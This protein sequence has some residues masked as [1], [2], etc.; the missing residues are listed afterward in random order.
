MDGQQFDQLVRGLF[1]SRRS[2]LG[3]GAAA[4]VAPWLADAKHCKRTCKRACEN[5]RRKKHHRNAKKRPAPTATTTSTTTPAPTPEVCTCPSPCSGGRVCAGRTC[6][7]PV[8]APHW[9]AG[10]ETCVP[11]CP[12]GANFVP[13]SCECRCA[14]R[15]SC[16][17]CMGG[18][19]PFCDTTINDP[20][21][22][23][24]LCHLNN[25]GGAPFYADGTM[26]GRCGDGG[27]CLVTCA[28]VSGGRDACQ[29]TQ[30]SCLGDLLA[31]QPLGGG[32]TRCGRRPATPTCGCTSHQECADTHGVGAF[33]ASI[34]GPL[35]TCDDATSFCATQA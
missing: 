11:A 14:E 19:A 26:T 34:T 12:T 23:A 6:E 16:C 22:C 10:A 30:R 25:P 21:S 9:C 3:L 27:Q 8:A 1:P 24:S 5:G 32:P 13:D 15:Q 31:F 35:C 2:L 33:C 28:P 4:G 18:S 20:T 29:S 17:Q 7:C